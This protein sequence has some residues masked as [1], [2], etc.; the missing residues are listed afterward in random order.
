MAGGEG[1]LV[2][3][4]STKKLGLP[5]LIC[6]AKKGVGASDH[7]VRLTTIE[8]LFIL[9]P[10]KFQFSFILPFKPFPSFSCYFQ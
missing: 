2:K 6:S 10:R 7:A 5:G 1:L 8:H 3:W 4:L 9:K